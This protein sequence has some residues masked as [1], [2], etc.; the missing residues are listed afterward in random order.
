MEFKNI[1]NLDKML[2][3]PLVFYDGE[4]MLDSNYELTADKN[5][6]I[7]NSKVVKGKNLYLK[8]LEEEFYLPLMQIF[9]SNSMSHSFFP[10]IIFEVDEENKKRTVRFNYSIYLFQVASGLELADTKGYSS[11]LQR[12]AREMKE[13]SSKEEMMAFNKELL[14]EE[15]KAFRDI[16]NNGIKSKYYT[17]AYQFYLNHSELFKKQ[18]LHYSFEQFIQTKLDTLVKLNVR[19]QD[20]LDFYRKRINTDKLIES[21]DYDKLSL[22]GAYCALLQCDITVENTGKLDNSILYIKQYLDSVNKY[23][24][25][26]ANYNPSIT[27]FDENNRKCKCH[28]HDIEKRYYTLLAEHPD[29]E[30]YSL[31]DKEIDELFSRFNMTKKE[32]FDLTNPDDCALL[33]KLYEKMKLQK[34]LAASWKFIPAGSRETTEEVEE[35]KR[36][37]HSY[38][39]DNDELTRR[40]IIGKQFIETNSGVKYLYVL[41]GINTFAGYIGYIYPNG[42]VVFEKYYENDKTYR[43][44]KGSA[45]YVMGIYNF[46]ELSKLSKTD[47]IKKLHSDPTLNVKRIFHRED[48]E[49][50]KR[51]LMQAIIGSDYTEEIVDYI[52]S[53]TNTKELVNDKN[54]GLK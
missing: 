4:W 17:K 6:L 25:Y 53:L 45:T 18:N 35:T 20:V 12:Y 29:F 14:R 21:F 46:L 19:S 50:W 31:E 24:E 9:N 5:I 34:Q 47:I 2:F 1:F 52:E 26:N 10:K 15:M 22:I 33:E 23:K 13:D 44:A 27:I 38:G 40:M 16:L 49:K 7:E 43:I 42:A 8:Y 11:V 39:I 54:K 48:M 28:I 51:E 30:F 32:D 37:K 41:H 36:N 3:N